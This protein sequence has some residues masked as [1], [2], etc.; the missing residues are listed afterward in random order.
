MLFVY[1]RRSMLLDEGQVLGLF[2]VADMNF[3]GLL[4]GW[5]LVQSQP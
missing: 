2:H 3:A 5:F 4:A 1:L